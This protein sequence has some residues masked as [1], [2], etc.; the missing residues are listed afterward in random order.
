[1][2][3]LVA[4]ALLVV[5][6]SDGDPDVRVQR[7]PASLAQASDTAWAD[8]GAILAGEPGSFTFPQPL[9]VR[10]SI[11]DSEARDAEGTPTQLTITSAELGPFG[12]VVS[13]VAT[14]PSCSGSF[15]TAELRIADAGSSVLTVT[16][17]GPEGTQTDC[18]YYAVIEDPSPG[19]AGAALMTELETQQEDCRASLLK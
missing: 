7:Q 19:A 6:C 2:R 9:A 4:L 10:I 5:G 18:F 16:A 8:G 12:T 15:C 13:E 1:M 17:V 11:V 14:A 3:F